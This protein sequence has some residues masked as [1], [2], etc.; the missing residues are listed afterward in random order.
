VSGGVERPIGVTLV[1][2][3][4]RGAGGRICAGFAR[5]LGARP[6]VNA[7]LSFSRASQQA[8][9]LR[10]IRLP[11]LEVTAY[12][13][14]QSVIAATLRAPVTVTRLL[15]AVRRWRSSVIVSMIAHPWHPVLAIGARLVGVR[16][17]AMVH[18]AR[19]H[20]GDRFPLHR[21]TLWSELRLSHAVL[22]PTRAV[23]NELLRRHPSLE[24][25][26][27]VVPFGPL[28]EC[29]ASPRPS[30]VGRPLR[31][32]VFGRLLPYKGLEMLE[33]MMQAL[34][35]EGVKATLDVVGEG[36]VPP[37]VYRVAHVDERWVPE[38]EIAELIGQ[39]D[40]VVL[41]YTS[42]SQSGVISIAQA[43][44]VPVVCTPVGGL[45]EQAA[46]SG[47]IA[48]EI[49]PEAVAQAIVRLVE[50]DRYEACSAA[51][52]AIANG[53]RSWSRSTSALVDAVHTVMA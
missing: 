41:P 4:R 10:P 17:V 15:W 37:S 25:R 24:D 49:S 19:P 52:I 51:G 44:G 12:E 35:E 6:D 3:G 34:D 45:A 28:V 9:M 53:A 23:A 42:G 13:S 8:G 2:W 16:Y 29:E 39:A 32:L 36:H 14:N 22:T 46:G 50:D 1:S 5:E 27:H 43:L 47:E 33:P 26:L 31:L 48:E 40:V 18:N 30:P 38:D 21:L 7:S 20:P 11:R